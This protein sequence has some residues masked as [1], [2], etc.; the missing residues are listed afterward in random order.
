MPKKPKQL[1]KAV[2]DFLNEDSR[3]QKREMDDIKDLLKKL[4]KHQKALKEKLG[5]SKDKDAKN[6]LQKDIDIIQAQR[7]KALKV[8]KNMSKNK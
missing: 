5:S 7:K 1:L 4:K 3:R 2:K 8:L 6:D